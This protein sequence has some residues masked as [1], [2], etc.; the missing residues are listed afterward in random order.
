M[1]QASKINPVFKMKAQNTWY[2]TS[3]RNQPRLRQNE[4][5]AEEEGGDLAKCFATLPHEFAH[6]L[7]NC[8]C[9]ESRFGTGIQR[10]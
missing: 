1:K 5:V 7:S 9:E 8:D 10:R 4:H 3:R 2:G 6:M